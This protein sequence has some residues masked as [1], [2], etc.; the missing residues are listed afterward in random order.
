MYRAIIVDDEESIRC[1]LVNHFD[2]KKHDIDV[3]G[4]FE[5]GIPALDFALQNQV[6]L[7]ITDVRMRHMDGISLAKKFWS[8]SLM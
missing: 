2:W 4:V 1:G 5:D 7:I 6:D 8:A 3:A